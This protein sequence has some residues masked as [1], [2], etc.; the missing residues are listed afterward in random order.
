VAAAVAHGLSWLA[1]AVEK[2]LHR[3]PAVVGVW[4]GNFWYDD[5]LYPL[6]FAADALSR[7]ER[8][9]T[10]QRPIPAAFV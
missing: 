5:R 6:I 7:A 8:Q 9:L 4:P 1:E 2:D 10:P 3:Q